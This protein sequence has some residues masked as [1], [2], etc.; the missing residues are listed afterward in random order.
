MGSFRAH[1]IGGSIEIAY[2]SSSTMNHHTINIIA[3]FHFTTLKRHTLVE[4]HHSN[5][6][7]YDRLSSLSIQSCPCNKIKN[8]KSKPPSTIFLE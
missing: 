2:A 4:H 5:T 7:T 1:F 3:Q 6:K 8:Q